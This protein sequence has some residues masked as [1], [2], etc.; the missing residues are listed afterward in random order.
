MI[1]YNEIVQNT[2]LHRRRKR[3]KKI[4]VKIT[5]M[6]VIMTIMYLKLVKATDN[7][8]FYA[9]AERLRNT[10]AQMAEGIDGINIAIFAMF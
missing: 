8:N 10:M 6:M 3:G 9:S 7:C 2:I 5:V 4:G 1:F